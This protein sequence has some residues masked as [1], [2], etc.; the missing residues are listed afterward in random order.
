MAWRNGK[1]NRHLMLRQNWIASSLNVWLRPRLPLG[2]PCH[3]I[4][5]S[6][7]MSSEPQALRASLYVF[8]LVVRYFCG[9]GFI[10]LRLT[11]LRLIPWPSLIYATKPI[12]PIIHLALLEEHEIWVRL[13]R[14]LL[15]D[16]GRSSQHNMLPSQQ[17]LGLS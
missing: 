3:F 12:R 17:N 2:L 4:T 13:L 14:P 5:G 6:S 9:A 10:L 15:A 16:L 1:L 11:D 7:Q 8:Q